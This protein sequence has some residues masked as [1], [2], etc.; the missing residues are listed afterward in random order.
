MTGRSSFWD[1]CVDAVDMR[2]VF[3]FG[4]PT[5]PANR[6][7]DHGVTK[8]PYERRFSPY[9]FNGGCVNMKNVKPQSMLA[10]TFYD[11]TDRSIEGSV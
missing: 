4:R 10:P 7:I 1:R 11:P 9:D 2:F 8:A 3:C 5:P 6:S